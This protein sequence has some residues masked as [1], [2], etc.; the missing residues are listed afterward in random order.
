MAAASARPRRIAVWFALQ[1]RSL[2]VRREKTQNVPKGAPSTTIGAPVHAT[3]KEKPGPWNRS[4]RRKRKIK[5]TAEVE[6]NKR[7]RTG[8]SLLSSPHVAQPEIPRMIKRK[9]QVSHKWQPS[10]AKR[11]FVRK[12]KITCRALRPLPS[13]QRTKCAGYCTNKTK[14][15]QGAPRQAP[16]RRRRRPLLRYTSAEHIDDPSP[17]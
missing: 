4:R 11:R 5:V 13:S 15:K 3:E 17:A 10:T 7:E 12:Q 9:V 6:L 1:P 8:L 16:L 14:T 2:R